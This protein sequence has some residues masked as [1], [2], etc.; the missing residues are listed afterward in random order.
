M[1]LYS[2]IHVGLKFARGEFNCPF[3]YTGVQILICLIL[4][5]DDLNSFAAA[6]LAGALF[7]SPYGLR[8][9]MIGSGVALLL[10]TAWN[11]GKYLVFFDQATSIYHIFPGNRESRQRLSEMVHLL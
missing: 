7:R 9:S 4:A 10:V 1:F 11:L 3:R 8:Q 6:G 2:A 5:D